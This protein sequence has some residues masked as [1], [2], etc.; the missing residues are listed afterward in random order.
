MAANCVIFDIGG[1]LMNFRTR[2]LTAAFTETQEDALLLHR[3]VF[4]HIDWIAMD[5]GG[6]EE[7]SLKRM[8]ERLPRRLHAPADQVMACW[9]EYLVPVPEMNGLARELDGA[10]VPLYLL[11]NTPDRFNRFRE[12]IPVWPLMRGALVSFEEHLLKP[13]L[14][15]YRRLFSRF[16]LSPGDCFFIDDSQANIEAARWCGMKGCL[17]RGDAGEVRNALRRA[18]I[19]VAADHER[20]AGQIAGAGRSE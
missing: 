16:G 19:P 12:R 8:K 1:V 13:D 3:E 11:S 10:G 17:Y 9:D 15:I 18:G 7:A 6:S 20:A 14:E 2:A 5:R 4:E